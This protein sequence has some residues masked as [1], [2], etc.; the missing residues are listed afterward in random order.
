MKWASPS[1]VIDPGM[2][3]AN[4]VYVAAEINNNAATN[5]VAHND[6]GEFLTV[7]RVAMEGLLTSLQIFSR[8]G[9]QVDARLYAYAMGLQQNANRR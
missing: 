4:T 9:Y 2:G 3:D 8:N 5:C 7:H 1:V 6:D